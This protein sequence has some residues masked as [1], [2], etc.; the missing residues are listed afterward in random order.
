MLNVV[1]ESGTSYKLY[2]C[3]NVWMYKFFQTIGRKDYYQV[4]IKLIIITIRYKLLTKKLSGKLEYTCKKN[5]L[6]INKWTHFK[7]YIIKIKFKASTERKCNPSIEIL[8][9]SGWKKQTN[10]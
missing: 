1:K 2:D 4:K 8:Y 5:Q 6:R 3:T 7:D 9:T 10:G